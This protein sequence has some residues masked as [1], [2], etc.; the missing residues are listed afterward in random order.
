MSVT[1]TGD[2]PSIELTGT[3]SAITITVTTGSS[4]GG[5]GVTDHG[6]LT[7]LAD[8]DHTQYAKKASNLSDLTDAATART[9]LGLGTAA[10]SATGDFAAASHT[11][12][13]SD[14][15]SGAFDA[16][17]LATGTATDGYVIAS[18]A[19]TPTWE[20]APGGTVDVV[21]N[22]A[23]DRILGRTSSGSG[24]SEELT[25]AQARTLLGFGGAT[26]HPVPSGGVGADEWSLPPGCLA[27]STASTVALSAGTIWEFPFAPRSP[28]TLTA[29]AVRCSTLAASSLVRVGICAADDDWQPSSLLD[30]R[31]FDTT[32][33]GVKSVTGL[34]ISLPAGRY[35]I[36]QRSEGGNPTMVR[37]N[38]TQS[39]WSTTNTL[40]GGGTLSQMGYVTSAADFSTLPKWDTFYANTNPIALVFMR[41]TPA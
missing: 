9:N 3:G 40:S 19:G 15:T 6:L 1:V 20:P 38:G 8:D 13:A 32:S 35:L 37:W 31:T 30:E 26:T 2:G 36:L 14:V 29:I 17:R 27:T 16:A 33:T 12:A 23:Q 24:D 7:G 11:H 5:G 21:S 34:S 25:A 22:V 41:W 28:I 18:N 4:S 10:T 39:P